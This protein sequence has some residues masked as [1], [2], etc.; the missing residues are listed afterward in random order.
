[1]S[2]RAIVF[3][4]HPW[5]GP[6][7][8]GAHHL[9]TALAR[10]G[11]DVLYVAAPLSPP[12]IA[13]LPFSVRARMRFVEMLS[14]PTPQG[15]HVLTP[16]TWTPLSARWGAGNADNLESW[17][18]NT[19]PSFLRRIKRLGFMAP[20]LALL[21]GPLQA[22]AA[23]LVRPRRTALRVFDRFTH[24]PGSSPAL[25]DLAK[26]V[27]R[28]ADLTAYTARTLE[29]DTAALEPK[30][31]ALVP[32]GVDYAHF[33]ALAAEP[34]AYRMLQRPRAV[35]VGQTGALFDGQ[36]IAETAAARPNVS[37][38]VIGPMERELRAIAFP[39]NVS[40]LGPV[41][42][43]ALPGYLRHADVGLAPFAVERFPDYIAAVNPLKVY[44]YLAA[45]LPVAATRWAELETLGAPDLF[46]AD[47][48]DFGAAL[49]RALAAGV[50]NADARRAF[51][52]AASWDERLARVLELVD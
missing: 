7:R 15:V 9:A 18:R 13:A 10:A 24:M 35:Y 52:A 31:A 27:A 22:A 12:H 5:G 23:R 26:R 3:G 45:G 17:P 36:L 21:D 25:L 48:G 49:D 29:T 43:S 28:E 42:Y 51:A 37:F 6:L 1:M 16:Y 14:P 50:S 46:L 8:L 40:L 47:R 41:A 44:E 30:R 34:E 20:D 19:T 2:K 33:S 4:A 11:Y 38:I 39:R 32:N